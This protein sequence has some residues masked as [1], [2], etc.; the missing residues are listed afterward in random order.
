MAGFADPCTMAQN[1]GWPLRNF[2]ALLAYHW[3]VQCLYLKLLFF[4][5]SLNQSI[6][7]EV[8]Y[9]PKGLLLFS[10]GVLIFPFLSST[11]IAS[12]LFMKLLYVVHC[13]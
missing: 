4:C 11:K 7:T 10:V 1:P 5:F 3:L 9:L 12:S 2:I 6:F 13:Y 8:V